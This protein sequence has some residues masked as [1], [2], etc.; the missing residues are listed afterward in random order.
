[1]LLGHSVDRAIAITW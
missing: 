1:M